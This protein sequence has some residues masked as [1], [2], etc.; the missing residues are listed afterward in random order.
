MGDIGCYTLGALKPLDAMDA[1]ICMGASVGM[2]HGIEKARGNEFAR[3]TVAVIGDSTFLHSG[4][5][6]LINMVYNQSTGTVVILDNS[7]T[8]MTGHQDNPATGKNAKGEPAPMIDLEELVRACGVKHVVAV[9][10]FELDKFAEVLKQETER[11]EVS[12]VIARR[13]CD[14][15]VKKKEIKRIEIH[16]CQN[17]GAC[18]EL[19]CPGLIQRDDY[20]EIDA[21]QCN[22]CGLCAN[23]CVFDAIQEV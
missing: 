9:D 1:C 17:C 14:L 13:P 2:A 15:I 5:T 16:D 6:G 19:G 12:V 7:I 4:I 3:K 8:G 20:V 18:M 23:V 11:P 22:G 10:P 21:A